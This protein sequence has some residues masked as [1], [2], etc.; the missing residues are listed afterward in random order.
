[1]VGELKALLPPLDGRAVW[2]GFEKRSSHQDADPQR[3]N[4]PAYEHQVDLYWK[5]GIVLY[6]NIANAKW[7]AEDKVDA[8]ALAAAEDHGIVPHLVTPTVDTS[9]LPA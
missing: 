6:V 2:S 9:A 4:L 1:M 7:R 3:P 8:G 5:T